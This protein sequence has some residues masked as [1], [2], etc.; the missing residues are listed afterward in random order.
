MAQEAVSAALEFPQRD[1]SLRVA[2]DESYQQQQI[3]SSCDN[4]SANYVVKIKLIVE[5][6]QLVTRRIIVLIVIAIK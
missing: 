3:C 4:N 5:K 2:V 1:L 6:A